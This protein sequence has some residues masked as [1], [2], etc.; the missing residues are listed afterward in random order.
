MA[1]STVEHSD[2]DAVTPRRGVRTYALLWPLQFL[3]GFTMAVVTLAMTIPVGAY[4]P[5]ETGSA[6]LLAIGYG[7]TFIFFT[8]AAP[9]GGLLADRWGPKKT[10]LASNI[11]WL[12][13]MA[14]SLASL[15]AGLLPEWLV[16]VA[17]FGRVACQSVQLTALASSIPILIPKRHLSQANGSRM[18][19]TTA[20][21]AFEAPIAAALYPAFG[22]RA[23][24]L[25]TCVVVIAAIAC[26]IPAEIPL[27]RLGDGAVAGRVAIRRAYQPLRA[28]IRSRRGLV[29]LFVFFAVFNFVVGFAEVAD[30]AITQGFGSAATLNIVLGAGLVSMLA[31]TVGITIWGTP[32]QPIRWLTIFSVIFGGAL[33]LGAARPNLLVVVAAAVL[34]LGCAPFIMGIISTM[35]HLKTEP[36]LMGRMMGLQT[37][38]IGISYGAGNVVGALC[39][40]IPRPLIGGA[41]LRTGLLAALVGTGWANGRGYAFLTMTVGVLTIVTV[42][43][44]SRRPSLRDID[45]T[46]PDVTTEDLQHRH[47]PVAVQPPPPSTLPQQPDG[48]LPQATHHPASTAHRSPAEEPSS[49]G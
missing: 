26:L 37:M 1:V 3:A 47:A 14:V 19:L 27:A 7:L 24:I 21:A 20:V 48:T 17:L 42:V 35:L 4:R 6:V 46:L 15:T 34:F 9:L 39:G 45:T 2:S 38:I 44:L 18:I 36:A 31:T 49:A 43:L 10:L 32:R 8:S 25:I 16:W 5:F 12:V 40:A 28:Y 41:H 30:G 13:L 22:L 11:G 33:V 29:T 23:M